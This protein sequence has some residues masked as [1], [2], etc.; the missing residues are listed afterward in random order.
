MGAGAGT[1]V[2]TVVSETV[3][4]EDFL[5]LAIRTDWD[6]AIVVLNKLSYRSGNIAK[7][8]EDS[9]Q[10]VSAFT[11]RFGKRLIAF[12]GH[13]SLPDYEELILEAGAAAVFRLP[14][15]FQKVAPTIRQYL[16]Q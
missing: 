1:T 8:F 14:T 3:L 6:L 13:A 16:R 15:D 10:F 7:V 12:F 2:L 4:E 5:N 11:R 9:V